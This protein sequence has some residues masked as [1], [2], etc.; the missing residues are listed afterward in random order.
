MHAIC[1]EKEII[2]SLKLVYEE[3]NLVQAVVDGK[4]WN[5][6]ILDEKMKQNR[7]DQRGS[8]S[9]KMEISM[10]LCIWIR[11]KTEKGYDICYKNKRKEDSFQAATTSHPQ[12][13]SN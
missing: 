12:D 6:D 7:K 5:F 2:F 3:G 10:E 13:T 1:R 8:W 9:M 11:E 4:T